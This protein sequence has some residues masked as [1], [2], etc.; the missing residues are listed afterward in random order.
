MAEL[1]NVFRANSG[2]THQN[3]GGKMSLGLGPPPVLKTFGQRAVLPAWRDSERTGD[4]PLGRASALGDGVPVPTLRYLLALPLSSFSGPI[5]E[6]HIR[7]SPRLGSSFLDNP[8]LNSR[9]F[10]RPQTALLGFGPVGLCP[11]QTFGDCRSAS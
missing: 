7:T 6:E 5:I 8:G 3:S 11:D 2:P 9:W 4:C 1:T 10:H